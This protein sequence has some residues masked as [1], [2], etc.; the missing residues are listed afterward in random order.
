MASTIVAYKEK[1]VLGAKGT[2]RRGWDTEMRL[3]HYSYYSKS[4][5][6]VN[7]WR[8]KSE[9][10][11]ECQVYQENGEGVCYRDVRPSKNSQLQNSFRVIFPN[12]SFE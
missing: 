3:D 6:N 12:R 1:G 9:E 2:R 11:L 5:V 8:E 4:F 7:F 10:V